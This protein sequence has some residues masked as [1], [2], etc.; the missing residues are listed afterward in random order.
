MIYLGNIK[1]SSEFCSNADL[2]CRPLFTP[3]NIFANGGEFA[4]IYPPSY[5]PRYRCFRCGTYQ[6]TNLSDTQLTKHPT[7]KTMNL[8]D[9]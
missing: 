2:Y 3:E 8:T 4:E 6:I 9:T 5:S 1:N 7:Y